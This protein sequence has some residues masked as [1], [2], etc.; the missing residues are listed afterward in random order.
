M[1]TAGLTEK[2]IQI[3]SQEAIKQFRAQVKKQKK[4]ERDWRLRNTKLLLENYHK[5]KSH[6]E[7]IPKQVEEYEDSIFSLEDLTLETLM[8]YRIKTAKMLKYFE[9]RLKHYEIDCNNGSDEEKRRFKIIEQRYLA[10][11]RL[12][13]R[14]L[15][16]RYNVEQGT[17]YRDSKLAIVDISLLLFGIAALELT[18]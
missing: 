10:T 3:I 2:Q 1:S 6:C 8:K 5:L 15:C 9:Q 7:D 4:Q 14:Q 18:H 13:V 11:E 17:I 12:T 16:E